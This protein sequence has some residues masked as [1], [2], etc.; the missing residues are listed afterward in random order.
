M[1]V[2]TLTGLLVFEPGNM[3]RAPAFRR[4][5][6][7]IICPHVEDLLLVQVLPGARRGRRNTENHR[8][9]GGGVELRLKVAGRR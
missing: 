7:G 4:N 1:K 8:L 6:A 3:Y 9:N 5:P 2:T